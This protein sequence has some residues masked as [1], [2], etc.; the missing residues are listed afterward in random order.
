MHYPRRTAP[1]VKN[2]VV[3]KKNNHVFTAARGWTLERETPW[4]GF[5]HMV[6]ARNVRD[7]VD[8]IPEWDEVAEGLESICLS[9]GSS[10]ADGWY[11]YHPREHTSRI[12]LEAWSKE[13]WFEVSQD[14][15]KAHEAIFDLIGLPREDRGEY[16]LCRFSHATAR[17]YVML[18]IF[19]HE[20]GHHVDRLR[21]KNQVEC[22]RGEDFAEAFALDLCDRTHAAWFDLVRD[23]A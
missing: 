6:S 4:K 1:G 14:H 3:Q 2:G 22:R 17:D 21:S 23:R 15:A 19:P 18:H 16:V 9:A 13:L 12:V 11:K 20:L 10:S 7:Y 8:L 5:R